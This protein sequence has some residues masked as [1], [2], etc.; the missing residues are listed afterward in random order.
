MTRVYTSLVNTCTM[1]LPQSFMNI[2]III[3]TVFIQI[4]AAATINFSLAWVRLLIKGGSYSRVAFINFGPILDGVIHENCSTEGWFSKTALRVIEIG[5]SK[6]LSR[7]S[8][9]KPI[10]S[11]VTEQASALYL[12]SWSHPLNRVRACMRLLFLSRSS[13]SGY[14][15]R[16][17]FYSGIP[18]AC[19]CLLFTHTKKGL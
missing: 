15:S 13:R 16:C 17:G 19:T 12:R 14:Y 2:V 8:K 18:S 3:H 4:V 9:T 10:P 6:K 11:S 5:S 1:A 7:C